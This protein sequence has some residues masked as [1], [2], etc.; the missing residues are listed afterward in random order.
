M[1]TTTMR[2]SHCGN[3]IPAEDDDFGLVRFD[4]CEVAARAD[5]GQPTQPCDLLRRS[6]RPVRSAVAEV[7]PYR[8]RGRSRESMTGA[9]VMR[10]PAVAELLGCST[11]HVYTMAA[12]GSIPGARRI[13]RRLL[14]VR[15]VLEDFP[16]RGIMPLN[17]M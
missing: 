9:D 14:F 17:R 11:R 16:A 12:H 6:V 3:A 1:N 10:A 2:L 7:A 13:G 5:A 8:V 15:P 4:P